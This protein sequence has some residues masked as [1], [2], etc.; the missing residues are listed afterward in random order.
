MIVSP[1]RAHYRPT[2]LAVEHMRNLESP[3]LCAY[4]DEAMQRL[5][6]AYCGAALSVLGW[7][8]MTRAERR[9]V[10][11]KPPHLRWLRPSERARSMLVRIDGRYRHFRA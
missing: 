6:A 7:H 8:P 9:G 1:F 10:S 4:Y 2:Y 5:Q 11:G 3:V